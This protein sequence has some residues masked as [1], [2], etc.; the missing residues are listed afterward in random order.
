MT[1]TTVWQRRWW[2]WRWRRYDNGD[3]D[4]DDYDN[5]DDDDIVDNDDEDVDVDD[6]RFNMNSEADWSELSLTN[7]VKIQNNMKLKRQKLKKEWARKSVK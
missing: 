4:T 5:E 7:D 1:T 6:C 2:Q 3:D